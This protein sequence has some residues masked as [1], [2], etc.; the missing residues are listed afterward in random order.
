MTL[1]VPPQDP[2]PAHPVRRALATWGAL[3]ALLWAIL[4]T[5]LVLPAHL[6]QYGIVPR[7]LEGLVPGIL[8]APFLHA[9]VA[10][11][12][13]N[14]VP[15]VVMGVICAL[16]DRR[17]MWTALAMSL[18]VSGLGVWLISPAHSVTV[19]AS[20]VVFGL[21]GYL[22]ARGVFM[23]RIGDLLIAVLVFAVYGSLI[24]G[25][26]PTSPFVSWQAHLFGFLGGVAAAVAVA[27]ARRAK[28]A[29]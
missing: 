5:D 12:A 9:D 18:V 20:G 1:P 15:L 17:G 6:T 14:T 7:T 24:W 2:R 8:A 27:R 21:L 10:H 25:V 22:L 26:L 13:A 29:A 23:R 11:L 16:R 19:G 4:L 28:A 3:A